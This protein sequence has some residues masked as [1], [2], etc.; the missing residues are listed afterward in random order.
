MEK[1]AQHSWTKEEDAFLRRMAKKDELSNQEMAAWLKKEFGGHFTEGSVK[2]R[3]RK[4]RKLEAE[5]VD[6]EYEREGFWTGERLEEMMGLRKEGRTWE[7]VAETLSERWDLE[8]TEGM[9]KSQAEEL[10][11]GR[12]KGRYAWMEAHMGDK[13]ELHAW[14]EEEDRYLKALVRRGAT[15]DQA[16]R[17]LGAKFHRRVTA[18]QVRVRLRWL[19]RKAEEAG[20]SPVKRRKVSRKRRKPHTWTTE[21]DLFLLRLVFRRALSD[22]AAAQAMWEEFGGR[23]FTQGMISFRLVTLRRNGVERGAP[24]PPRPRA[25]RLRHWI[26]AHGRV[27]ELRSVGEL[28][29]DGRGRRRENVYVSRWE[30]WAPVVRR[31]KERGFS[32][33]AW[34]RR[35]E[36]LAKSLGAR[37]LAQGGSV[38]E[39]FMACLMQL[40]MDEGLWRGEVRDVRECPFLNVDTVLRMVLHE[41]PRAFL[42][43]RGIALEPSSK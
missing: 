23:R 3:L 21:E 9:V 43:A 16:A 31:L 15:D 37:F 12:K 33:H 27:V 6:V 8:I 38:V 22:H 10:R 17:R 4:L 13:R 35:E 19:R 42:R 24:L 5:G 40:W 30:A 34:T 28:L 20:E 2:K 32:E 36:A 25:S 41:Y 18:G 26:D 14:T 29:S 39:L 1:Q 7:E 11:S